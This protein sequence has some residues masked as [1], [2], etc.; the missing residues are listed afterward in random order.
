MRLDH[1]QRSHQLR[2]APL[3]PCFPAQSSRRERKPLH[4]LRAVA[5][6]QFTNL[7]TTI[8][9]QAP[10]VSGSCT[11][12]DL[13]KHL[14]SIG[15]HCNPA[16]AKPGVASRPDDASFF[17]SAISRSPSSSTFQTVSASCMKCIARPFAL[18]AIQFRVSQAIRSVRLHTCDR[19]CGSPK[20]ASDACDTSGKDNLS[21]ETLGLKRNVTRWCLCKNDSCN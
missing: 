17:M 7:S 21:A 16:L 15:A 1:A 6:E 13:R 14:V 3:T 2:L 10:Y 4:Q 18:F 20:I 5:E 9:D 8:P 12:Q 19:G 11:H